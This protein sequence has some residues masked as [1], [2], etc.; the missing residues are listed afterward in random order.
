MTAV[1]LA[2]IGMHFSEFIALFDNRTIVSSRKKE[3]T[4]SGVLEAS[5]FFFSG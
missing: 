3:A 5:G 2:A 1:R 4:P